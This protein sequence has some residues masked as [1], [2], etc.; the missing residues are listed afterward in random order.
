[1]S[2]QRASAAR[3]LQESFWSELR[4]NGMAAVDAGRGRQQFEVQKEDRNFKARAF[5]HSLFSRF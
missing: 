3:S 1:M 4:K 5:G 2:L